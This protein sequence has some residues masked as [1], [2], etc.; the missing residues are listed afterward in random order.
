MK[1][2][3]LVKIILLT[4]FIVAGLSLTGILPDSYAAS[5]E[6]S[7]TVDAQGGAY[8]RDSASTSG[9]AVAI[10]GNNTRMTIIREVFC[11]SS[12]TKAVNRWYYV[13]AN[14]HK[15]Y[16]RADLVDSISYSVTPVNAG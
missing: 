7:G 3:G 2:A 8:I 11:N 13:S 4:L 10:L 6:A 9:R 12:S 16:I 1:K 15:G 5:V 14:G